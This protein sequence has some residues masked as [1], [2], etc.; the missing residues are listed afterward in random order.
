MLLPTGF[1][2]SIIIDATFIQSSG[3]LEAQ[4][5]EGIEWKKEWGREEGGF[6]FFI[7]ACHENRIVG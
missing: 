2:C 4:V 1:L 3:M 6:M 7:K 5:K